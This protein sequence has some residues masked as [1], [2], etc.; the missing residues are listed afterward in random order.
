MVPLLRAERH[1]QVVAAMPKALVLKSQPSA[2]SA[3]ASVRLV[4]GYA[5]RSNVCLGSRADISYLAERCPLT[6][7][8]SV[9]RNDRHG[10]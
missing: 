3:L 1:R 9:A 10:R 8:G 5:A 7:A 2:R 4:S 6:G